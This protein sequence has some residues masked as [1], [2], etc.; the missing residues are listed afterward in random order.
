M[1]TA[2]ALPSVGSDGNLSR[3]L[4]EIRRFPMLEQNEEY[5]LA[6]RWRERGLSPCPPCARQRRS[7]LIVISV[8]L[9]WA[10]YLKMQARRPFSLIQF[11]PGSAQKSVTGWDISIC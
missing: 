6:K 5:M 3:Y 2:L 7:L 1:A 4:Q 8:S 11:R 9:G 10:G